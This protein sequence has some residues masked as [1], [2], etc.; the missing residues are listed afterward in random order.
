[1][2][3]PQ[4]FAFYLPQYHQI[5]ENDMFWG[6][7]FTDW[8]TVKKA[9]PLY[10]GHEQ[11]RIPLNDNYYDLSKTASVAWQAKIAKENG[12]SG[13]GIYHYWF[14]DEQNI[15]TR[16]AEIIL[17]NKDIN[18]DY[19]FTWDNGNW[20]RSWSNLAGNDWSPL[21]ED[22]STPQKEEANSKGILIPYVLGKE[23][24]W[25]NHFMWLLPHFK[26]D[27]YIKVDKKPMFVIYNYSKEIHDMSAYWDKLAQENGFDGMYIVYRKDIK[28]RLPKGQASYLYEP[29]ASSWE[30]L[31]VIIYRKLL[32][33]FHISYG[34][35]S[36]DY[37]KVWRRLLNTME[38]R[39]DPSFIPCGFVGYD[40]TPRRGRRGTVIKGQ[41]PEKFARYMNKLYE[42]AS[43][44]EKPFIF[45]TA[46]NEWGEGAYIEPDKKDKKR[47]LEALRQVRGNRPL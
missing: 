6:E 11:P 27:R 40:D 18:I 3:T 39:P 26:D 36:F 43:H 31:P 20:I 9:I 17:E 37:D 35:K 4:I 1:M 22:V 47:Y 21:F 15:L 45:L 32:K 44:Q 14:N 41:T 34:P 16:P 19:F 24:S 13:F 7:G 8:V 10:E 12:I 5:P 29:S 33:I 2:T 46:W 28:V 30:T 42:L 23:A 38:K 25:R